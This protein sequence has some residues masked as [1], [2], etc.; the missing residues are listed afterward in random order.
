MPG[1]PKTRLILLPDVTVPHPS[2][3]NPLSSTVRARFRWGCWQSASNWRLVHS[4]KPV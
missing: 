2:L 1:G 3:L 4:S